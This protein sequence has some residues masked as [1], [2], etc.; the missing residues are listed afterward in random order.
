MVDFRDDDFEW[1]LDK[2]AQNLKTHGVSFHEAREVFEGRYRWLPDELHSDEEE[3]CRAI[4]FS[5]SG[6][7]LTVSYCE[8]VQRKRIISSWK[9]SPHECDAFDE[10]F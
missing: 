10:P 2:E 1:D 8:R 9:S 5:R 6:R 4:G 7:I 3:R